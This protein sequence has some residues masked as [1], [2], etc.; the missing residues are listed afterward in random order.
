MNTTT[1]HKLNDL[2][3][4]FYQQVA[5]SFGATRSH[6]WHGWSRLAQALDLSRREQLHALDI[7]CGNL[8]FARFLDENTPQD[9]N[10]HI[11]GLDNCLTLAQTPQGLSH[12]TVD[13]EER[14]IVTSLLDHKNPLNLGSETFDLAVSFG[15]MHHIPGA[16]N[17]AEFLRDAIKAL[18]PAGICC[19]TLWQP[20]NDPRIA[21]KA[22]RVISA[23]ADHT[24]LREIDLDQLE[25]G[26]LFLGWQ[27][28]PNALRYCHHFS[29]EESQQLV[30]SVHDIATLVCTFEADGKTENLN[31]YI[32]L[33]SI[34]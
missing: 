17:R 26:D 34:R 31:R 24:A 3:A 16:D 33:R 8:R 12:T 10:V 32:V 9:C 19:V 27:D 28:N 22:E 7:A 21:K 29:A 15:F 13:F 23:A 14:D 4:S 1:A 6:G 25:D 2:N 18:N 30:D 5:D 20:L 11:T